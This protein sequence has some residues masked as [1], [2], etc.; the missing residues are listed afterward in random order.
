M[1]PLLQFIIRRF[2]VLPVSFLVITLVLYAG[3]MLTPP[4]ARAELYLPQRLPSS[5]TEEQIAQLKEKIIKDYHLRDPY[6]IQYAIWL[7][8][9]FEGTWGYSPSM[10]DFVLPILLQRTPVTLELALYSILLLVPLGL[11][12]GMRSG[13]NRGGLADTSF[14]AGA[15]I[16]TSTP[17]FILALVLLSIFYINLKW[18]SPGRMGIMTNLNLQRDGFVDYTGMLTID[19]LINGRVDIFFEAWQH[20]AMPVLTLSLYHW[21]TLGRVARAAVLNERTKEYV[22][23][24]RARGLAERDVIWKHV[25][26]NIITPSLTSMALSAASIATGVFVAEII[27]D[28]DGLSYVIVSAMSGIPDAPAA[29]G[30]AVYSVVMVLLFMFLVDVLQAFFDP[31]VREG[32]LES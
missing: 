10:N 7:R 26:K 13:W 18:F 14:R 3:V 2:L 21:A 5:I 31:R 30:F 6:P 8:S 32:V 11:V 19:S 16:A 9:L 25:Y 22:I 1:P 24:A 28:F 20:L 27:F 4:E 17:T 12:S 29:L 15:F 23:A